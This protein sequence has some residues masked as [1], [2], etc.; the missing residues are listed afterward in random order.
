MKNIIFFPTC[1]K[2][3][4]ELTNS[5]NNDNV[6]S[7]VEKTKESSTNC[8]KIIAIWNF[9]SVALIK[10]LKVDLT[11]TSSIRGFHLWANS[12]KHEIRYKKSRCGKGVGR[13]IN[14]KILKNFYALP[15]VTSNLT[16][17][18]NIVYKLK[19]LLCSTSQIIVDRSSQSSFF[20]NSELAIQRYV[21]APVSIVSIN[22]C[23][24]S[25]LKN[26]KGRNLC[27]GI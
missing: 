6:K 7:I 18:S 19:N 5:T 13:L 23:Y 1:F 20:I 21:H 22:K 3:L 14:N 12:K 24:V 26:F 10:Q 2:E 4:Y 17:I 15:I 25:N 9:G 11:K 27:L 16:T 8:C